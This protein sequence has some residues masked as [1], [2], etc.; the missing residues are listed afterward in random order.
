MARRLR[1]HL[2]GAVFHLTTRT[3]GRAPWFTDVV[4]TR[5]VEYVAA[6]IGTS[7]ATLIAYAVMSN[8]LHL[9]VRQ[10][11]LS[12][13][14]IMQPLLRMT[15][16]L[17][18]RVHGTEGHVFERRFRDHPCLDPDHVRNAIVYVHLN[19]VRAGLVD[20]PVAYRWSSHGAYQ[21]TATEPGCMAGVLG[22]ESGLALFGHRD[23]STAGELRRAYRRYVGWRIRCDRHHAAQELGVTLAAPPP[24][25]PVWSGDM[26]WS[27]MFAAHEAP[28]GSEARRPD[29]QEIAT[30]TLAAVAPDVELRLIRSNC[31]ARPVVHA[32]SAVM[33]RMKDAG[34]RGGAIARYLGVSNQCVSHVLTAERRAALRSR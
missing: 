1:S 14:R 29:L 20:D 7:D 5:I 10:G 24:A 11:T 31:K 34:Y 16:S 19:P 32:R 25:P 26:A 30:R 13:G 18:Q 3:Q 22:I 15:A 33:H 2:P 27:R 6:T 9:V 12:L 8:H 23:G 4:R 28:V 21:A 17:V